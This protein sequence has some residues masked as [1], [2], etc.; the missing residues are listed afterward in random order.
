MHAR[1]YRRG[2]SAWVSVVT[3]LAGIIVGAWLKHLLD[4]RTNRRRVVKRRDPA[5]EPS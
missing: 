3:A 2:M 5:I 4:L 1:P